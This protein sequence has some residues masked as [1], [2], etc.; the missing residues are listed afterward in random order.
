M[1]R[2]D[3][4]I[5]GGVAAGPKTACCL[6]RRL[7]NASITL[8]QREDIVSYA[9]CGLPYFASGDIESFD[10]L[11]TTGYGVR[12]DKAFFAES[13]GVDVITG[14]EIVS[15]DR[16]S[17]TVTVRMLNTGET[18]EHQY[19]KLVIATGSVPKKPLFPV[20]TSDRIRTFTR[21]DDA[22]AFRKA[23]QTG[24]IGKVVIVGAGLIGCEVAEAAAGLWGI[25]TVVLEKE[26][27]ILPYA[28]DA[29]MAAIA[30]REMKRK[31][32]EIL[33]SAIIDRI[34]L[35]NETPVVELHGGSRLACNYVILCLGVRPEVSL[36]KACGLQIG[37]RGGIL[38]D[39]HMMTSDPNI[40]AGGD[41]VESYHRTTG[42]Y[43]YMPMG[44][45]ANKHGRVIA[46]N[47]A[48]VPTEFKGT[49]GSFIVKIFDMNVGSVG[50]THKLADTIGYR[51]E[52]VWGTFPDKPDYFPEFKI[53]SLKMVYASDDGR[54]LG[55]QAVG[56]GDVC[57]RID[58]FSAL[59]QKG[60]TVDDLLNFEHCYAPPYSEALDPMH[61]LGAM[62]VAQT[63]GVQ[64]AAPDH[65]PVE[66][67]LL[68]DLRERSEAVAEPMPVGSGYEISVIPLG[69][70]RSRLAD[71]DKSRRTYVICRRG[72]RAYQAAIVLRNEGFSDVYVV[73]GGVQA[74]RL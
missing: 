34:S 47:L 73:G 62:A 60:G 13:K 56:E 10:S 58:V 20:E 33:T 53:Y 14:A 54:I 70:L 36:A 68:I 52:T 30:E 39:S 28:L 40:Y 18:F 29:D 12:R 37:V 44:S 74:A 43:I 21:P 24:K 50:I 22:I 2:S 4:V 16:A 25:E 49:F 59:L 27:Q 65:K 5:I 15:I 8:Y 71:L 31:G 55:L 45:L 67:S 17:K 66:G 11:L 3:I 48:G 38:V 46:E 42:S 1:K 26:K 7:Q 64:F 51:A 41:C 35:H 19:G 23:A 72:P 63:R 57:R 69:E 9:G 61:H 6:A 32:V